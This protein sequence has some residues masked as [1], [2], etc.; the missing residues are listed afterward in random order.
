MMVTQRRQRFK[1]EPLLA[2]PLEILQCNAKSDRHT[3]ISQ[4][5]GGFHSTFVMLD[6]HWSIPWR[7]E[8]SLVAVRLSQ[9]L[10]PRSQPR[11]KPSYG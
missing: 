6:K 9:P 8:E 2:R 4:A 1:R 10:C 5:T 7:A 11:C 3:A